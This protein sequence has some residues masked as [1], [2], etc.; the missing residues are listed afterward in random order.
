MN[1]VTS[2]QEN[3]YQYCKKIFMVF[4][5]AEEK[6]DILTAFYLHCNTV[7]RNVVPSSLLTTM[8]KCTSHSKVLVNLRVVL[9][10]K[11][12][13]FIFHSILILRFVNELTLLMGNLLIS[14]VNAH[15][16]VDLFRGCWYGGELAQ[17][18]GQA[19]LGEILPSLR[20]S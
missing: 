19:R 15:L 11:I 10:K 9:E 3:S 5:L 1:I 12:L 6:S 20:N 17:P 18:G 14:W 8:S 2:V 7:T 16:S 13:K 4:Y